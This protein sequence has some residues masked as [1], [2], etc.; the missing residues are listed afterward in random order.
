MDGRGR[1]SGGPLDGNGR[2]S[3]YL[4]TWRNFLSPMLMAFDTPTPFNTIGRRSVSNVPAQA[5]ILMNDPFVAEQAKLWA[6][7]VLAEPKLTDEQRVA[8][9][10]QTAFARSPTASEKDAVLA[11]LRQQGDKREAG[12]PQTWSDLAHVLMN[13]KEFI[14]IN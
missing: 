4:T 12:D 6:K 13:S 9:M 10:Y 11:F 7:R 5:L 8:L 3:V 1:Q 14:Y 2:R